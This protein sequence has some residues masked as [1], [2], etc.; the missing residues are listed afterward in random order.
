MKGTEPRQRRCCAL[1]GQIGIW[2]ACSI[3]PSRPT[4]CRNFK[5]SWEVGVSNQE[6]DR[7]RTIYGLVPFGCLMPFGGM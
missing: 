5:A 7:A 4:P 2:V 6:C 1:E 3:Y